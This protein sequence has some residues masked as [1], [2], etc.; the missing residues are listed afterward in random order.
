MNLDHFRRITAVVALWV[1]L[2]GSVTRAEFSESQVKAV[3]ISNFAQFVTWP[4][5]AFADAASPLT[6][7]ILGNDPFG[8]ELQNAIRGQTVSNRSISIK[9]ASKADDLRNC[10]IVFISRSEASQI[11]D[12]L[13]KFKGKSI[14]TVSDIDNFTNSGGMIG[15]F[16]VGGKVKFTVNAGPAR[17]SGLGISS[18][19]QRLGQ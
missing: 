3:F 18:K 19:I 1:M 10:Q 13:P 6:I 15:L 9:R 5:K 2:L 17:S 7:G 14:L 11:D 4:A 16:M 12:I 8:G